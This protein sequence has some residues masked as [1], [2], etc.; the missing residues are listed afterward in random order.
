MRPRVREHQLHRGHPRATRYRMHP[1]AQPQP[2]PAPAEPEEARVRP[3]LRAPCPPRGPAFAPLPPARR[4]IPAEQHPARRA[5]LHR[6]RRGNRHGQ[7]LGHH[8]PAARR[9]RLQPGPRVRLDQ[10]FPDQ[11]EGVGSAPSQP[12]KTAPAV[13][14]STRSAD[15]SNRTTPPPGPGSAP[16]ARPGTR[17]RSTAAASPRPGHHERTSPSPATAATERTRSRPSMPV[18]LPSGDALEDFVQPPFTQ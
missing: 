15:R 5:Q 1:V 18:S 12:Q 3:D 16:T 14:T 10:L 6:A 2:R 7:P 17:A 4:Q 8:P 13:V 9:V 11:G